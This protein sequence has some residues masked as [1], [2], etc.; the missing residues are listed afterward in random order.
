MQKHHNRAII[1]QIHTHNTEILAQCND[2]R[3]LLVL[4]PLYIRDR[5]PIISIHSKQLTT[6]S[7]RQK[8][9]DMISVISRFYI[10][11]RIVPILCNV[12]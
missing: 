3:R 9:P 5:T 6:P 2:H 8:S 10:G 12:S 1:I 11:A 4:E 7:I